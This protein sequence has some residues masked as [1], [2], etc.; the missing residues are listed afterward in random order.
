MRSLPRSASC[1]CAC[2]IAVDATANN[3]PTEKRAPLMAYPQLH[4]RSGRDYTLRHGH[5]AVFSG[6]FQTSPRGIPAG[7]VVDVLDAEG[8]WLARG[9]LNPA[10]SLAFRALTHD[11]REEID[12]AFYERRFERAAALRSLLPAEVTAYRLVHAE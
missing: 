1:A 5:A 12:A 2:A 9:H 8:A 7:T 11:E 6:A 10:N 3:E 4:L